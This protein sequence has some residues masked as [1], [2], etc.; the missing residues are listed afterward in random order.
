MQVFVRVKLLQ[1][2]IPGG[3]VGGPRAYQDLFRGFKSHRVHTRRD[4]FL[5]KK[6]RSTESAGACVSY[7][8]CYFENNGNAEPCA[9]TGGEKRRHL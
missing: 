3:L 8:R 9:R 1:V 7:V 6:N 4:F 2:G 5:H